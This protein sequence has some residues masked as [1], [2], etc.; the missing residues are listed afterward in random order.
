MTDSVIAYGVRFGGDSEGLHLVRRQGDGSWLK[1]DYLAPLPKYINSSAGSSVDIDG[2]RVAVGM[3]GANKDNNLA[4]VGRVEICTVTPT[5]VV[6]VAAVEADAATLYSGQGLGKDLDLDGDRLAV[7]A[8][9]QSVGY[10]YSVLVFDR[11]PSG[12]WQQI[13]KHT[14][15]LDVSQVGGSPDVALSGESLL[16]GAT[17]APSAQKDAK[18]VAGLGV[19]HVLER[20][21]GQWK[22]QSALE[23]APIDR[24][25]LGDRIELLGDR[26]AVT[27]LPIVD[28]GSVRLFD[29]VRHCAAAGP[30]C[31]CKAGFSGPTCE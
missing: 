2:D 3:P 25:R 10:G 6:R 5:S 20:V 4:N 23:S 16:F 8:H 29:L 31:T 27:S 28:R 19:V 11:Q 24:V 9:D 30:V 26:A 22:F 14:L 21:S 12:T 15:A 17:S 18:G 13:F 1:T 7:T